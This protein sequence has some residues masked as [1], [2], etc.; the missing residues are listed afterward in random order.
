M[1]EPRKA[2][3]A[4]LAKARAGFEEKVRKELAARQAEY[5]RIECRS[6]ILRNQIMELTA[7][8]PESHA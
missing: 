1:R 4:V 7:V 5:H 2:L 3:N 8:L 6:N